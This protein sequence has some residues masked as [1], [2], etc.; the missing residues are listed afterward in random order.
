MVKVYLE[1]EFD[2]KVNIW[3]NFNSETYIYLKEGGV[4]HTIEGTDI[5]L[6]RGDTLYVDITI[7]KNGELYIPQEG[8]TIRFAMKH[9]YTDA[10]VLIIKEIPIDTLQLKI[11]PQDTKN[12]TMGKTYVY[13]IELTNQYGDVDTFII[14]KFTISKEVY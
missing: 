13:D 5:T 12:L 7:T 9:K 14:G 10:D 11:E 1:V 2:F 3:Y 8:D 4:M 6:T